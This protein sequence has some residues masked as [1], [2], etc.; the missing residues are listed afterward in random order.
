MSQA[1]HAFAVGVMV[2]LLG[3]MVLL[4]GVPSITPMF[5]VSRRYRREL[6]PSEAIHFPL[7]RQRV[8]GV[9]SG[10]LST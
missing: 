6:L 2:L 3:V 1:C 10:T 9:S 5:F 4:L 8:L 7:N